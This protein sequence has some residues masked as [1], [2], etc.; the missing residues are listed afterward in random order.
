MP[1]TEFRTEFSFV[2]PRGLLDATGAVHQHGMMRLAT[3]KDEIAIQKDRRAQESQAY[4]ELVLFARVITQLGTLPET[5]PEVL[6][7]L[8][9]RDLA[10]LREFYNRVNQSGTAEIPACCPNCK[11]SFSTEFALAGEL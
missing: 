6:E 7:G 2:L 5:T 10:Y 8:F 11:T 9:T 1:P 3:A 4:G